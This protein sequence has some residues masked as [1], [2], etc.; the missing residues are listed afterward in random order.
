MCRARQKPFHTCFCCS[1]AIAGRTLLRMPS[2]ENKTDTS[3]CCD[4]FCQF[5][6]LKRQF[7]TSPAFVAGRCHQSTFA[8]RFRLKRCIFRRAADIVALRGSP[9][10]PRQSVALPAGVAASS[11]IV[12]PAVRFSRPT[13]LWENAQTVIATTAVEMSVTE[14]YL[15]TGAG[16]TAA[17]DSALST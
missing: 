3:T 7:I 10:A 6:N 8:R 1:A 9:Q 12:A 16:L 14:L 5:A 4:L 11:P 13:S 17:G 15:K 2:R